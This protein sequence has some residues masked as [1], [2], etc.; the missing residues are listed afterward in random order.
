M[1]YKYIEQLLERYWECQT[2]LQEENILRTFFS[3]ED[4]PA[5]LLPYKEVFAYQQEA[6]NDEVLSEDFDHKV[7]AL[8]DEDKPVKARTI[9]MRQRMMPFFKAAAIVAII[10]TLQNAVQSA[11]TDKAA[12]PQPTTNMAG[13]NKPT[14]GPSMAKADSAKVDSIGKTAKVIDTE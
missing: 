8:I 14:E 5:E 4:V 12:E 1:D 11:L 13:I 9:T 2:T 10:L 7:L 3:Q 6:I